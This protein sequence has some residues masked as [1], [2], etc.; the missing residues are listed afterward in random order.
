MSTTS[1]GPVLKQGI[2]KAHQQAELEQLE[3]LNSRLRN[4]SEKIIPAS[5]Y[6]LTVPEAPKFT[7]SP[8]HA[9]DFSRGTPFAHNEEQLQYISFLNRD[10]DH[11]CLRAFGGWDNEKGELM[12]SSPSGQ[13]AKSGTTT[14]KQGQTAGKKMSLADY[15][16]KKAGG[17]P[18]VKDVA[19]SNGQ[20]LKHESVNGTTAVAEKAL[21]TNHHE[22]ATKK[23]LVINCFCKDLLY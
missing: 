3:Q 14:P 17:Q 21:G 2:K 9:A 15:K 19:K 12:A 18:G 16:N 4:I 10:F 11:G 7:L 13:F 22:P 8:Q 23:R 5:P 20:E 6:I 1:A